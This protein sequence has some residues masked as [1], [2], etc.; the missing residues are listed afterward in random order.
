ME[1]ICY[2]SLL[3]FFIASPVAAILAMTSVDTVTCSNIL[4]FAF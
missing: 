3:N 1:V 2:F 4:N